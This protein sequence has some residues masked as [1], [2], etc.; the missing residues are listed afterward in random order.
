MKRGGLFPFLLGFAAAAWLGGLFLFAARIQ[1]FQEPAITPD[2]ATTDAI[3]VLTGGSE[4]LA[5]GIALLEAGRGKKLFVSG[6]HKGLT[7]DKLPGAQGLPAPLRACCVTLGYQAG[8]TFGNADETK[9][10][11]AAQNYHSL[12]L[13]TANYHMPRSL[14][15]FHAAMPDVDIV[16]HPVTPPSVRMREWWMHRGTVE[17]LATEY[18]K[19]L[20]A[21]L[22]L[23]V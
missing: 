9:G 17:L 2:L 5:T 23:W 19:F 7:L 11:M 12:R 20:F 15:L 3:V 6:V 16:P 18:I 1:T 14:L 4:R 10:W 13:V 8:S 21:N 22:R